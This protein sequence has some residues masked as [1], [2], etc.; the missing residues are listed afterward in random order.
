MTHPV[1][2]LVL[3][4]SARRA[5]FNQALA[6]LAAAAVEAQG[7]V[8]TYL[9]IGSLDIP[10]YN[11]DDEDAFGLPTGVQALRAQLFSHDALIIASPEY[12]GFPSPLL[13][14]A[15]DWASRKQP[16]EVPRAAFIGKQ[17]LLLAASRGESGGARGLAQLRQLLINLKVDPLPETLGL[18]KA[19]EAFTEDGRLH[20]AA[21][22][23]ELAARVHALLAVVQAARLQLQA[24]SA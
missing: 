14:N 1:R 3:A 5:S 17:A 11:G 21:R 19:G 23:A 18:P 9:D 10:L 24:V 22:Q 20:D 8:A 6:R 7:G 4:G 13:K 15:L 12:N 16:D 2:V